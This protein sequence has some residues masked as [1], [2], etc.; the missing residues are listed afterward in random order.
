MD[1]MTTDQEIDRPSVPRERIHDAMH[2]R[3]LR[4]DRQ[5]AFVAGLVVPARSFLSQLL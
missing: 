3:H 2:D 5:M 4:E 1:G